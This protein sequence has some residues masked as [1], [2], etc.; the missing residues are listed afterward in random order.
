[1]KAIE[2][3]DHCLNQVLTAL[4]EAG[5]EMLITADHGNAEYMY[6]EKTR[7]AHTAHTCEPVPIIYTG[8]NTQFVGK[9]GTLSD[10]APSILYLLGL[11]KPKEMAGCSLFEWV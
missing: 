10:V 4:R 1:V 11:D 5:G 9:N 3:I 6:D 8:Q 2:V 7:Q